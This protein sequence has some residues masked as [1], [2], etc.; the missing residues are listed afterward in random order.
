MAM[1]KIYSACFYCNQTG[2]VP[3]EEQSNPALPPNPPTK[4]C[5]YC[6]GELW[7]LEGGI[8][9]SDITDKQGDILDKCN[10]ILEQVSP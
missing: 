8:D 4:V 7:V 2:V 9:L 10:D 1:T 3:M 6:D 5:P